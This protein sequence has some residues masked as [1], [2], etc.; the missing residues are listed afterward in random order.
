M[1]GLDDRLVERVAR[2]EIAVDRDIGDVRL[3]AVEAGSPGH[4]D[5]VVPVGDEVH[6]AEPKDLDGRRALH[7]LHR[8]LDPRPSGRSIA[9]LFGRKSRVKSL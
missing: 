4:A 9:K 8:R 6:A 3:D 5:A 2:L 7:A 1:L